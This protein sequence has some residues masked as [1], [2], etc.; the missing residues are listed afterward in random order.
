MMRTDSFYEMPHTKC[1]CKQ[2]FRGNQARARHSP[3]ATRTTAW[4]RCRRCPGRAACAWAHS[5]P[6]APAPQLT[7]APAQERV[8]TLQ[9]LSGT[10]SLR[11]GA[12]F[13]AKFM[14]G[15]P[16]YLSNP[17][18]CARRAAAQ[19]ARWRCRL[20]QGGVPAAA[21]T[22]TPATWASGGSRRACLPA[23]VRAARS[24]WVSPGS[25]LLCAQRVACRAGATTRTSSWTPTWSGRST[26]TLTRSPLG[27]TLRA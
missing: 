15:R 20:R 10:G 4:R 23:P 14:P 7:P 13:L 18:W 17:T 27:W 19:P 25:R 5:P 21:L 9:A 6:A 3:P 22:C 12:A 26:A 24:G 11:V 1:T 2:S 8:A 16:V